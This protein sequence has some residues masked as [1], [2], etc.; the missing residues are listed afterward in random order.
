MHLPPLASLF[1]KKP[2]QK[3]TIGTGGP[4]GLFPVHLCLNS[5]Q[6]H[7]YCAGQSGA[8][9]SK[10]LESVLVEAATQGVGCGLLDPHSDL[11]NDFVAQLASAPPN[12]AWLSVAQNRGRVLYVD[13]ARSDYLVPAN[14]LN[15]SYATSYETAELV[16][17]AFRRVWPETLAEAPRFAQIMRNAV[18]V[19]AEKGLSLL[20][21]EP[22]LTDADFRE[23][24]LTGIRD[25]MVVSFFANQY[26]RWGRDQ[27]IMASPVLNKVSAFLFQPS[28]RAMLGA[29]QNRLDFRRIIDEGTVLIVDLGGF[30]DPE[31]Q[32]LLGSLWVTSM[33][34]AAFSRKEQ[35][36]AQRRPFFCMIDEF[37]FFCA[38]DQSSLARI[39]SECR[40][41][42]LH[43]GLA[44]QTIT[45]LQGERLQGALENAKLKVIFGTGRQTAAAISSSLF[46][47]NPDAVKHVVE[48]A[49]AQERSHPVYQHLMEQME[50]FTQTLQRLK[51]RRIVVKLPDDD[52]VF[53]LKTPTV[54]KPRISREQLA[55]VKCI[56]ARQSGRP[57]RELEQEIASRQPNR[58]NQ[59]GH[60]AQQTANDD[61]FWGI[62]KPTN[63]RTGLDTP[64]SPLPAVLPPSDGVRDTVWTE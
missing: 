34:Q 17:E 63:S 18:F 24:V 6:S 10:W 33:E 57:R 55:Q 64:F 7:I 14:I 59:T 38:R 60:A 58:I 52:R 22:F 41:Y 54:P 28:V 49:D 12:K 5:F 44:H 62:K 16:I 39:L 3:V 35:T 13:P 53:K 51:K 11:A 20:E 47:P 29:R 40:K 25:P 48:D 36:P 43:L 15:C 32:R 9:K 61:D 4:F 45:Q 19:L 30:N 42:R 27:L 31:T 37:P 50:V 23:Y 46:M 56:L 2:Q 26:A 8:G 21:L 1:A